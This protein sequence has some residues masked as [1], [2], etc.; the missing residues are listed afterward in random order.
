M[1]G[2]QILEVAMGMIFVYLLLSLMCSA[3]SELI[4]GV[5]KRR[6]KYLEEG[7]RNLLNDPGTATKLYQ[8]PLIKA[9]YKDKSLP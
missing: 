6:A 7:I 9:L 3:L 4:E 8:H 5:L 2:S 1:F